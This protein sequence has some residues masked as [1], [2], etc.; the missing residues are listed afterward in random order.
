MTA[1]G[2][3]STNDNLQK[4]HLV[5]IYCCCICKRAGET[6]NHLLIHWPVAIE[7]WSMVFT[8][9]GV[10][11]VMPSGVLE[12]LT[13]WPGKFSRHR[14]GVIWNV[15]PHCLIWSIWQEGNWIHE[16]KLLFFQTLLGWTNASGV[17]NFTSL[18]D[19]LDNRT[20]YAS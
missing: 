9:F 3:I 12:L 18:P 8:L 11:L 1:L 17:S 2:H 4:R 10:C 20:F 16:L 15:I 13:S 19:L 5:I 6:C 14:N 7:M